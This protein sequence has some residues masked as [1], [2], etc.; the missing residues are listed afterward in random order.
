MEVELNKRS[1]WPGVCSVFLFVAA[2]GQ[3]LETAKTMEALETGTS[4][5][6]L[7]SPPTEICY[8]CRRPEFGIESRISLT[9]NTTANGLRI[10][11][12]DYDVKPPCHFEY[13]EQSTCEGLARQYLEA[14]VAQADW[15]SVSY[16]VSVGPREYYDYSGSMVKWRQACTITYSN[17]PQYNYGESDQCTT[18]EPFICSDTDNPTDPS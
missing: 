3:E 7:P 11:I 12:C 13:Y 16:T 14:Q 15:A 8:G 18:S 5:A 2:C 4:E 6:A 1:V 10:Q 9:Y 17:F